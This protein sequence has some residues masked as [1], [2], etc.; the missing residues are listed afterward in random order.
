[1]CHSPHGRSDEQ[2]RFLFAI[3]IK[4]PVVAS[5]KMK[6][7]FAITPLSQLSPFFHYPWYLNRE[8]FI[9]PPLFPISTYTSTARLR[10][11]RFCAQH[12]PFAPATP[13]L[14][15]LSRPSPHALSQP[16]RLLASTSL[17]LF[18]LTSKVLHTPASTNEL[19]HQPAFTQRLFYTKHFLQKPTF[20]PT[21]FYTNP[22]SHK[23]AFPQTTFYTNQ[24]LHKWAFTLTSFY[25]N[26]LF[27]QPAFTQP[28]FAPTNCLTNHL[29]RKPPF[30]PTSFTQPL[31]WACRPKAR[32]P[33]KCRRL[34]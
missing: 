6:N 27:H 16:C 26:Q 11:D 15:L 22:L 29:L 18:C 5:M 1:M 3:S 2:Y 13:A 21:S 24:L 31:L 7:H 8:I 4:A 34:L 10:G 33:A 12:F 17:T 30:T 14:P 32:G 9:L 20:T 19:L 23:L 28:R 25:A